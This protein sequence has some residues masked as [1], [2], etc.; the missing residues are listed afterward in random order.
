MLF[1][2]DGIRLIKNIIILMSNIS[3]SISV[4]VPVHNG[5]NFIG[6]TIQSILTQTFND[7]ELILVNDASTDDLPKFLEDVVDE[8]LHVVHLDSNVGVANARNIGVAKARG[9]FIAFCDADDLCHPQRFERQISYL[10]QNP[11]IGLCGTAFTC[12]SD[13]E[14][15][16]TIRNVTTNEEIFSHLMIGNCFGMSTVMGRAE[17]FKK[18]VF[19]QHMSPTED[20]DLW[21]RL[22]KSGVQMTNLFDSLLR[23]RVHQT[24]AS[25]TKSAL[26]DTLS[27]KI[28]ALYCAGVLN[29]EALYESIKSEKISGNDLYQAAELVHEYSKKRGEQSARQF[30]FMLAWMYEKLP[31]HNV[32]FW[33]KWCAIQLKLKLELDRNYRFNIA[34]MALVPAP[35][36]KSKKSTLLKLKR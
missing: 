18:N 30:R 6:Q 36:V 34:L 24:Q 15:L 21:T 28:R 10:R 35:I 33:R 26:L 20:Y 11:S 25:K 3:P 14:E 7:F 12:F 2:C 1:H 13:I 16:G 19:D 8:R 32:F 22:A 31:S 17:I 23:Y 27:K 5:V 9:S 29:S 4:V